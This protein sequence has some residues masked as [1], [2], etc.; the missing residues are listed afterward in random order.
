MKGGK[1]GRKTYNS[2]GEKVLRVKM[3]AKSSGPQICWK[4]L[5]GN[6]N[7]PPRGQDSM[8]FVP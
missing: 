8:E 3:F 4:P 2:M 6:D 1:E 5:L 7:S